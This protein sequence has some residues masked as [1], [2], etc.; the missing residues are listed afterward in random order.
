MFESYLGQDGFMEFVEE[1]LRRIGADI[2]QGRKKMGLNQTDFAKKAG[3]TRKDVSRLENGAPGLSW[4]KAF[5]AVEALDEPIDSL[6]I[7]Y[8]QDGVWT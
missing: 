3:L 7:G 6:I 5:A 8:A 2:A 1:M 4:K